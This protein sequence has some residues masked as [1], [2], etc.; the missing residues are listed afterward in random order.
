M[1][2]HVFNSFLKIGDKVSLGSD[3]MCHISRG[4]NMI[5]LVESGTT[6]TCV[7]QSSCKDG[8]EV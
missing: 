5:V 8:A 2:C 1:T 4:P 6:R 7:H 3:S